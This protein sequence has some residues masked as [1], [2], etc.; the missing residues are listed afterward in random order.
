[1]LCNLTSHYVLVKQFI[2]PIYRLLTPYI[3]EFFLSITSR[4]LN[5]VFVRCH[6]NLSK[7]KKLRDILFILITNHLF[8]SLI[9]VNCRR[10]TL[11]NSKGYSVDKQ[12]YVGASVVLL[13]PAIARELLGYVEHVVLRMLPIYVFEIEAFC[14]SVYQFLKIALSKH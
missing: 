8:Y 13:I 3:P 2:L 4:I 12:N 11:D 14:S 9:N 1:M 5:R 6:Y 7:F 10:F